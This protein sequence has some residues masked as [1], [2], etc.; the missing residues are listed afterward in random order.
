MFTLEYD[1]QVRSVISQ[2]L[3]FTRLNLLSFLLVLLF[4]HFYF[5]WN[6]QR[7]RRYH[8]LLFFQSKPRLFIFNILIRSKLHLRNVLYLLSLILDNLASS[9]ELR[10]NHCD[11]FCNLRNGRNDSTSKDAFLRLSSDKLRLVILPIKTIIMIIFLR[12]F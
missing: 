8:W 11:S 12:L 10:F 4:W 3:N 9:H 6:H 2:L 5:W 7:R 1:F